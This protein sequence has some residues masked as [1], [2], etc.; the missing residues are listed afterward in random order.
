MKSSVGRL[1]EHGGGLYALCAAR[2]GETA[3]MD[4]H[5]IERRLTELEIK[6]S[7]AEDTVDRLNEVLVRQQRQIDLLTL[8]VTRLKER[9]TPEATPRSL[10]D[11]LP[12]HY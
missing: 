8:E 6:A 9:P 11:E 2:L 1:P 4:L 3:G 12:P 7:F 10:R 5:D